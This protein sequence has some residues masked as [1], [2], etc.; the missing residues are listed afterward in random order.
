MIPCGSPL[1]AQIGFQVANLS[2]DN[3]KSVVKELYEVPTLS[4]ARAARKQ[5]NNVY[6]YL[7]FSCYSKHLLCF[8]S[9]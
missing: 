3:Y 2:K 1:A 5:R 8:S 4:E 9:S 7:V 6:V